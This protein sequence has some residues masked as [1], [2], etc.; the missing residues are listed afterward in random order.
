[1]TARGTRLLFAALAIAAGLTLSASQTLAQDA[2]AATGCGRRVL[3]ERLACGQGQP[4]GDG[5]RRK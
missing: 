5:E 1:M 2:P 3:G 4:R